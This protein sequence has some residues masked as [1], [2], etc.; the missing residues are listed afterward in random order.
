M[1]NIYLVNNMYN[2]VLRFL[3]CNFY[4]CES[5]L[6]SCPFICSEA[7]YFVLEAS[8]SVASICEVAKDILLFG[9]IFQASL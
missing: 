2:Y 4:A 3:S 5:E 7:V 9:I 8:V 6:D 1:E